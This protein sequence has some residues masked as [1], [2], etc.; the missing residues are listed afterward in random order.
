LLPVPASVA[1]PLSNQRRKTS[2]SDDEDREIRQCEQL[3]SDQSPEDL[4]RRD[5]EKLLVILNEAEVAEQ[6]NLA[7]IAETTPSA[8]GRQ[9][10]PFTDV[11]KGIVTLIVS[12]DDR[13]QAPTYGISIRE[14]RKI[15]YPKKSHCSTNSKAYNVFDEEEISPGFRLG[16]KPKWKTNP[17]LR[18]LLAL[19]TDMRQRRM[20]SRCTATKS[21]PRLKAR[22]RRTKN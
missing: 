14:Q 2:L 16:Y 17:L 10:D 18:Y 11:K 22:R 19:T 8:K 3:Y 15:N 9:I 6:E 13:N 21:H 5:L 12:S 20:L 7:L 4:W 1:D